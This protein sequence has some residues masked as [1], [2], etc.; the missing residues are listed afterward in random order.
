MDAILNSPYV[1]DKHWEVCNWCRIYTKTLFVSDI[2]SPDGN[3]LA[4][5][6]YNDESPDRLMS[7]PSQGCPQ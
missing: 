4:H 2:I 6:Y 7:E 5:V 3:H 1:E